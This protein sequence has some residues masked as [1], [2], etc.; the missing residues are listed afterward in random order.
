MLMSLYMANRR[1]ALTF[2]ETGTARKDGDFYGDGQSTYILGDYCKT[3]LNNEGKIWTCDIIE[4][5]RC[6]DLPQTAKLRLLL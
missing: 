5:N 1:G 2:V 3:I 4:E 6:S